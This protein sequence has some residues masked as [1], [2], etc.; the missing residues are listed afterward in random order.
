MKAWLDEPFLTSLMWLLMGSRFL[1][2]VG[3]RDLIYADYWSEASLTVLL[4]E[5]LHSTSHTCTAGEVS[6]NKQESLRERKTGTSV[7]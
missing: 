7:T 4:C 3:Q 2:G 1:R 6:V 5:P